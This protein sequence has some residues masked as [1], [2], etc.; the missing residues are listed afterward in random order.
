[1]SRSSA[2]TVVARISQPRVPVNSWVTPSVSWCCA[3]SANPLRRK[4]GD[5]LLGRRQVGDAARQ[6]AVGGRVGQPAADLRDDLAEVHAVAGAHEAVAWHP[7]VEQGDASAGADDAGQLGEERWQVDEVAQGETAGHPV[8]RVRR[9]PGGGGCRPGP[10][11]AAV[12]GAQHPEAEIDRGRPVPGGGEVD[13]QVAGAAGEIEHDA[14]RRAAPR[15]ST[16]WRRHRTS[17][18]N[19]MTRLTRS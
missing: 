15:A 9:R 5:D 17:R 10:G 16:A 1:M 11:R 13:A 2:S 19:V 4:R 7:D 12:V 3:A 6:I 8:D 14:A 18:R